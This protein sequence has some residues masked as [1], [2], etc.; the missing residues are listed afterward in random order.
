M[1]FYG[2][3]DASKFPLG[4]GDAVPLD[5]RL[6]T[7]AS[8]WDS[9]VYGCMTNCPNSADCPCL[10]YRSGQVPPRYPVPAMPLYVDYSE[11]ADYIAI[12]NL[13]TG[14]AEIFWNVNDDD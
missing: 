12:A 7:G 4:A 1:N 13:T 9:W 6:N 10:P 14:R 2:L 11:I 5:L 8:V 3:S